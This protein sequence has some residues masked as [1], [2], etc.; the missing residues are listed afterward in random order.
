M[1]SQMEDQM[2]MSKFIKEEFKNLNDLTELK[3]TYRRLCIRCHPDKKD[4]STENFQLLNNEYENLIRKI[5]ETNVKTDN[6]LNDDDSMFFNDDQSNETHFIL[7]CLFGAIST[8][9]IKAQ[10]L[11]IKYLDSPSSTFD[12]IINDT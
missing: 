4:G 8:L 11:L 7:N 2:N 1:E 5:K 10:E 3:R 12:V 6:I 9:P